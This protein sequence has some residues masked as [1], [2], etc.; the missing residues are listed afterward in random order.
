MD[1]SQLHNNLGIPLSIK[2]QVTLSSHKPQ[3]HR[4]QKRLFFALPRRGWAALGKVEAK[5]FCVD[6]IA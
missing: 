6:V 5:G 3:L 1:F 4:N 2:L